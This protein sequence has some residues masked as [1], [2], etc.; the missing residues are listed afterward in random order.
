MMKAAARTDAGHLIIFGLSD[1]NIRR[2]QLGDP[3][4][5]DLSELGIEGASVLIFAGK[6]EKTMAEMVG[7]MIGPD[8]KVSPL[9]VRR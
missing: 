9:P 4:K 1:E 7:D 8:T 5:V 3:I 6:D 2:L